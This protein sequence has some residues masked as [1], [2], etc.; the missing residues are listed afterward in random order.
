M[1]NTFDANLSFLS[2]AIVTE[3]YNSGQNIIYSFL[4]LVE[5]ALLDVSSDTISKTELL[6]FYNSKYGY[7]MPPAILDLLLNQLKIQNKIE[8]LKNEQIEIIK[9]QIEDVSFDYERNTRI[10]QTSFSDFAKNSFGVDI[11]KED[12]L[13]VIAD[14][15]ICNALNMN[16]YIAAI[17]NFSEFECESTEDASNFEWFRNQ[18]SSQW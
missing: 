17:G 2:Y 3:K 6:N 7:E 13:K 18:N 8:F 5:K 15:I 1:A 14:F 4:P 16:S 11:A 12:S 10:L 9:K